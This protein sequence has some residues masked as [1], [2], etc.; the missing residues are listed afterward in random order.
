MKIRLSWDRLQ[1]EDCWLQKGSL[2]PGERVRL[3]MSL[4]CQ[5]ML[6]SRLLFPTEESPSIRIDQDGVLQSAG[7]EGFI[8]HFGSLI[9]HH[10]L[11]ANL[12]L[13]EN[14]LLPL[15]YHSHAEALE[16]ARAEVE[17]VAEMIDLQIGLDEKAGERMPLIHALV[18]LGRCLLQR[19]DFIVAQGVWVGMPAEHLE[20]FRRVSMQAL[21]QLHSGLLYL[22]RNE[23]EDV[24]IDFD[25]SLRAQLLQAESA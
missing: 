15:L 13:R 9:L 4:G 1:L 7:S 11:I 10:G 17:A 25:R 19:P 16:R 14:L 3:V 24:G 22:S 2:R 6:I 21:Q 12:T 20:R 8:A 18:S 23:Q 5:Q